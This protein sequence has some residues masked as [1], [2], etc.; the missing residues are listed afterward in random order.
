[1][2]QLIVAGAVGLAVGI[3]VS[4]AMGSDGAQDTVMI[5][6]ALAAGYAIARAI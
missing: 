6:L 3:G 2:N 5:A 4:F 1:M